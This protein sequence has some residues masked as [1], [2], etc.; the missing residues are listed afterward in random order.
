MSR[1]L[2]LLE[3]ELEHWPGVKGSFD[4]DRKHPRLVL[5]YDGTSRFYCFS[6]SLISRR[7][8]HNAVSGVRKILR[9][10]GATRD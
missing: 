7:G 4:M 9:Q 2:P 1:V 8:I 5:E 10:L 6:N 3:R